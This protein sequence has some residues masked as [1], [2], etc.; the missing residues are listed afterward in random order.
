M[1][2]NL[3]DLEGISK[4]RDYVQEWLKLKCVA[5]NGPKVSKF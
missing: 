4:N 3:V 5:F 1:E 2:V